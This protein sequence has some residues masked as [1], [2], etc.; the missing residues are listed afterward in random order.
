MERHHEYQL[1]NRLD[2]VKVDGCAYV[3]TAELRLWYGQK[4]AKTV[5]QDLY[6]RWAE[7]FENEAEHLPK[8]L[9]VEGRGGWFLFNSSGIFEIGADN[10]SKVS[11]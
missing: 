5:Y 2:T 4:I 10:W 9:A 11:L 8:L 3:S 6:Q 7:L 1:K